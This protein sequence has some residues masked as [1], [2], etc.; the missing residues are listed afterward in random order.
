[1]NK[2]QNESIEKLINLVTDTCIQNKESEIQQIE[3]MK[4][5]NLWIFG[6]ATGLEIFTLSNNK[7]EYLNGFSSW[8]FV[9]AG[10]TFIYNAFLALVVYQMVTRLQSVDSKLKESY[11]YQRL[12]LI[13]ALYSNFSNVEELRKDLES[14]ELTTKLN[15]L[16]YFGRK[17]L[18]KN[19]IIK[20]SKRMSTVIDQSASK[21]LLAQFIISACLFFYQQLT[22]F[23]PPRPT[24][25]SFPKYT[26][27]G[28]GPSGSISRSPRA[29]VLRTTVNKQ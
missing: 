5:L 4:K 13:S 8:L 24:H 21:V 20:V 17:D 2:T 23:T 22:H 29:E 14:G 11:N 27:S 1:M 12:L 7:W 25:H 15:G 26:H 6:L 9:F 10:L 3:T 16:E 18:L 28:G 19:S